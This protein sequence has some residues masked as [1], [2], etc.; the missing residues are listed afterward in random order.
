MTITEKVERKNNLRYAKD[1]LLGLYN[2]VGC[3]V[4]LSDIASRQI[5]SINPPDEYDDVV[6][7]ETLDK[8]AEVI[9]VNYKYALFKKYVKITGLSNA[10]KEIL[11]AS[12]ISAD[13]DEDKAYAYNKLKGYSDLSLDGV[14]NFQMQ[15]LRKKWLEVCGY[16]P[17]CFTKNQ[18]IEFI[19]YLLDG[20]RK[21]AY[22]DCGKVYDGYFRRVNRVSLLDDQ[23]TGRVVREVL[24]SGAGDVELY[25]P[26]SPEDEKYLKEFFLSRI[27]F[28]KEFVNKR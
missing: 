14:F 9:C 22:V 25:G 26:L 8:L 19:N 3:G 18:L 1:S 20:R 12:L 4:T 17:N 11:L 6:K 5:L 2:R 13:F 28:R 27:T 10:E 24:L 16:M 21:K 7:A 23:D 15:P